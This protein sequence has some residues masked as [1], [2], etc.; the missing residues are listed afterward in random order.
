MRAEASPLESAR[1]GYSVERL[2]VVDETRFSFPAVRE[3]VMGSA[4]DVIVLR[5]PAEYVGWFAKLATLDR[6]AVFA[7]TLVYWR[8]PA[9]E[10]RRPEPEGDIHATELTSAAMVRALVS[11]IF[12]RYGNHYLANPLFGAAAALEGYQEWA[13]RSTAAGKCL[14]LTDDSRVCGIATLEEDESTTEILLAGV[15]PAVQGHGL[16]AHLLR[17]VEDRALGR[18]AAEVVISTQGHNTRVQ[19][20]WTRYGFVPVQTLLTVHLIRRPLLPGCGA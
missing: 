18:G 17:A 7:D 20:A 19:R 14:A 4:A 10:G 2:T 6:T 11:E 8:L 3:A 9:G 12:V 16:Y 15:V 1:F 5:Y 13:L